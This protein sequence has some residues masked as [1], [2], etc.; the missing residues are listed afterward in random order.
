MERSKKTRRLSAALACVCVLAAGCGSDDDEPAGGAGTG[1]GGCPADITLAFF[2]PLTGNNSPQ[3]GINASF[4]IQ[5]ALEEH[6]KKAGACQVKYKAYD[7]QA[8]PAQ[9]PGLANQA[10]RDKNIIGVVGPIYSGE[11]KQA[12]PIFSEGGLPTITPSATNP[13]LAKNG[14]KTFHRAVAN[15]DAQGPAISTYVVNT[16]KAKT[17][18]VIDDTSEYG[19]GLGDIVRQ[20]LGTGGVNVAVNDAIDKSHNY[21]TAVNK[22]KAANVDVVVFSGYYQEAGPLA[23]Q[24]KDA[25]VRSAFIS[26]DGS[27]DAD[28]VTGAGP[29]ADGAYLTAPAAFS[30]TSPDTAGF[31]NAYKA[32]YNVEPALYSGD[33]YDAANHFLAA[34]DAGKTTRA[35]INEHITGTSYKGLLKT[36]EYGPDG[37]LKGAP[38]IYVHK[39]VGGRITVEGPVG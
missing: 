15:D 34:I 11:S 6:N 10:V 2:G 19:K 27:L 5:L 36:Y 32:K 25:G 30:L 3:L 31:V 13:G 9:A 20:R 8:D 26:G 39:V 17:A 18:A 23:K 33:G 29:A 4:G 38:I 12:G 24:L 16:L 7:S 1:D 37:E 35:A 28:F 22:V 14:W 21:P